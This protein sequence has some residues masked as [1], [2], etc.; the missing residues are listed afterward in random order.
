MLNIAEGVAEASGT[1]LKE[2]KETQLSGNK[3]AVILSA[4]SLPSPFLHFI[5]F[6]D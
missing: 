2:E 3:A 6:L 4:R 5:G 1:K